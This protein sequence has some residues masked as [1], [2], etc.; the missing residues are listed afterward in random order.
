MVCGDLHGQFFDVKELF[1]VGG[2]LS[3][4]SNANTSYIMIGD[5][6]DRGYHS[7]ETVTLLFCYKVKYPNRIILL[8]G[9]H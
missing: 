7:V 8:R 4:P 6:V 2:M 5:F 1:R 9:N 3:D